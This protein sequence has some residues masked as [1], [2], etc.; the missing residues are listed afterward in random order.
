MANPFYDIMIDDD[1]GDLKIE[2]G[3]FV[4]DESDAQHIEHL[5]RASKGEYKEYPLCG[6]DSI[7]QLK[8]PVSGE[9]RR[10]IRVQLKQ[11]GYNVEDLIIANGQIKITGSR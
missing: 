11:D 5:L 2:N 4:I 7:K 8:G 10:E 3:D 1:T 6:C 9:F